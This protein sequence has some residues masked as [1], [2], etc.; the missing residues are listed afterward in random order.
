MTKSMPIPLARPRLSDSDIEAAV[1]VLQSGYF[2]G[3][4]ILEIF[5][6]ELAAYLEVRNAVCVSSGTAALHIGLLSLGIGPGDDVI[7]PA[8]SYP[9][10]ANVVELTGARPVFVDSEPGGFNIDS[11]K[12]ENYIT[13]HTRAIMIVHNFGW[14]A[15]MAKILEVAEKYNLPV[16][17]DAACALGSAIYKT[18]CGAFGKLAAFSFHPRKILTTGEG[19]AVTTNDD[20][21]ADK[22]KVLRNHGQRVGTADFI[23]PGFNYRLTEFQASLGLTQLRRFDETI[24]GRRQLASRYY[25]AFDD[26]NIIKTPKPL[27]GQT[28]NYQTYVGFIGER[29]RDHLTEYL[30]EKNVASGIGTYSIPHTTYYSDKYHFTQYDFPNSLHAY[31]NLISLPLYENMSREEQDAVVLGIAEFC[32]EVSTEP[33]AV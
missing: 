7:V 6:R 3:G 23:T 21:I 19:G 27:A 24:K 25:A 32:M 31:R 1:K 10:T 11:S 18:K 5:E 8:F 30:K 16:F 12:I 29:L 13:P 9:A 33:I 28:V 17:E 20:E 15:D 22:L 14:P 26:F 4:P 2:V